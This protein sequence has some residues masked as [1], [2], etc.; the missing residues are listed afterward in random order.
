MNAGLSRFLGD[1]PEDSARCDLIDPGSEVNEILEGIDRLIGREQPN[2]R[3]EDRDALAWEKVPSPVVAPM[4]GPREG[5]W[6][7]PARPRTP[8]QPAPPR[9]L[10]A[11]PRTK[12]SSISIKWDRFMDSLKKKLKKKFK[13]GNREAPKLSDRLAPEPD[14]EVGSYHALSPQL[15]KSAKAG[16]RV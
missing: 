15:S 4:N 16:E 5:A 14:D 6:R 3:P 1:D 12:R 9:D 10:P 2:N 7:N 8:S 11:H 13:R